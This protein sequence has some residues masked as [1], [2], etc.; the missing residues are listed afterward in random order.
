MRISSVLLVFSWA[1][2]LPV[3]SASAFTITL[4]TSTTAN[5]FAEVADG[6]G[7]GASEHAEGIALPYSYTVTGIDGVASL[8]S[9]YTLPNAEFNITLEPSQVSTYDTYVLAYGL[10]SFG[11]DENID[12]V[13]S[14]AYSAVDVGSRDAYINMLPFDLADDS[15]VFNSP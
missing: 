7:S 8:D 4:E 2:W 11:A 3:S 5:L 14:D 12:Y 13:A 6:V 1:A 10:I 9:V 15:A